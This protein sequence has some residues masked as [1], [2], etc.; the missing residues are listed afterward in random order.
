MTEM[1]AKISYS[2]S[3]VIF[4]L[5]KNKLMVIHSREETIFYSSLNAQQGYIVN[6]N[7]LKNNKNFPKQEL[8]LQSVGM[9]Q[10]MPAGLFRD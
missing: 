6:K 1:K 7:L 2:D 10:K 5:R 4:L 3:K 8:H 9:K